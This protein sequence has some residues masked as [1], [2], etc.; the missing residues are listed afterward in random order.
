ML[1]AMRPPDWI[2]PLLAERRRCRPRR[3]DISIPDDLPP[4]KYRAGYTVGRKNPPRDAVT[5]PLPVPTT[6]AE[7]TVPFQQSPAEPPSPAPTLPLPLPLPVAADPWPQPDPVQQ[8]PVDEPPRRGGRKW[9]WASAAI[10]VCAMLVAGAVYVVSRPHPTRP[11]AERVAAPSSTTSASAVPKPGPD[12]GDYR[13]T[14][15]GA[16]AARLTVSEAPNPAVPLPAFVIDELSAVSVALPGTA[17]PSSPVTLNFSF[18][19]KGPLTLRENE[20]PAVLTVADGSTEPE[21]L[22]STW[23]ARTQT[24]TASTDHLSTFFP[25]II[26]F[27]TLTRQFGD[28]VDGLLGLH[29]EEPDCIGEPLTVDATTYTLDPETVPAAFPCVSM[30]GDKIS[31]DLASNSPN[32]WLV[33]SSPATKDTGVEAAPDFGYAV[34][35]AAYHTIFASRIGDGTIL[36]PGSTTHLRFGR[37]APPTNVG[38]RADPGATLLNGFLV[39]LHAL[40]P[41]AKLL[42]LAGEVDCFKQFPP[43]LSGTPSTTDIG[44]DVRALTNCITSVGKTLSTKPVGGVPADIGATAAKSL[45]AVLFLDPD[46]ATQLAASL[47]GLFGEG[48][49]SGTQ[50]IDVRATE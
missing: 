31:V 3:K 9:L 25:A 14:V 33:R 34:N 5:T 46:I 4:S 49:G 17:Q 40:Y 29:D 13:V 42:D 8:W 10:A 27:N 7:P 24:L 30:A 6:P 35:K 19:G 1:S 18:E 41:D 44:K 16:Q 15:T 45:G 26:D 32:A 12:L 43:S 11:T 23:D 2:M 22:A 36:L 21:V 28:A 48:H 50:T 47:R 20:A 39:G 37:K 38:L